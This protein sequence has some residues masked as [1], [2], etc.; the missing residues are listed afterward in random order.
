MPVGNWVKN[1]SSAHLLP[2]GV[3]FMFLVLFIFYF[4]CLY[5]VLCLHSWYIY[6]A[7]SNITAYPVVSCLLHS[8]VYSIWHKIANSGLVYLKYKLDLSLF[9][10]K[11]PTLQHSPYKKSWNIYF[12]KAKHLERF[13][14][15]V[16][17]NFLSWETVNSLSQPILFLFH[18]AYD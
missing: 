7:N 8:L 12:V 4:C 6:S 13:A 16:A 10:K 15:C 2:F 9:R 11:I 14:R 1:Y 5:G 3:F 18:T 17:G